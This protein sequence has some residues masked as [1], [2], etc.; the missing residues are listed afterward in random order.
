MPGAPGTL[1]AVKRMEEG[2]DDLHNGANLCWLFC[3]FNFSVKEFKERLAFEFVS[4]QEKKGEYL[5]PEITSL[6]VQGARE[7][8]KEASLLA[9]RL[10]AL[11]LKKQVPYAGQ[12]DDPKA[13]FVSTHLEAARIV[14]I[15][16]DEGFSDNARQVL[17]GALD[18]LSRCEYATEIAGTAPWPDY[19]TVS[20]KGVGCLLLAI[21]FSIYRHD[22]D[23]E[24]ALLLFPKAI[25]RFSDAKESF[26]A[27]QA[28]EFKQLRARLRNAKTDDHLKHTE[29]DYL[30]HSIKS[31]LSNVLGRSNLGFSSLY[32]AA[33]SLSWL[34]NLTYQA[35]VDCFETIRS[36]GRV[37]D[38]KTLASACRRLI[39]M[40]RSGASI[41]RGDRLVSDTRG[42]SWE[43]NVYWYHAMG[44]AET[45]LTPS[46]LRDSLQQGEDVAAEKR[47]RAYF[48][49]DRHWLA[50]PQRAKSSLI[51]ADRDYFAGAMSQRGAVLN[52]LK[53]ATE[54]I[55]FH[56]LWTPL[57]KWIVENDERRDD[58][59]DFIALEEGLRRKR[60]S[61]TLFHFKK[62]CRMDIT[63][64]FLA[65]LGCTKMEC[66]WLSRELPGI[67]EKL[68]KARDT[69]EHE[70][71][72]GVHADLSK[73]FNR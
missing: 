73:Y 7:P 37:R 55:L 69:T 66:I 52:E 40:C 53:V 51:N 1:V 42:V 9:N 61:P 17:K 26:S 16:E 3:N 43:P 44:W 34:R 4:I 60:H 20:L 11:A 62:M 70:S 57:G 2:R 25:D 64:K 59:R 14:S 31:A 13:V 36:R 41:L 6:V 45:L 29:Y 22:C 49:D 18:S 67:L 65:Q 27:V 8:E 10:D 12:I 47:M 50:L 68:R 35:P 39:E 23:Y 32:I 72:S 30:V 71:S 48:F 21:Q 5:D 38:S 46:D 24:E 28:E 54:E 33:W 58:G 56:G 19:L 15:I 63:A